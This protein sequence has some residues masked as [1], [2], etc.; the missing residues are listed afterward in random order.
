MHRR[1]YA[2][3]PR[4]D[5]PRVFASGIRTSVGPDFNPTDGTLWLTYNQ[6]DGMGDDIPPDEVN[7]ATTPGHNFGFPWYGGGHIRTNEY[8]DETPPE[9][10]R[11]P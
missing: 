5:R 8:K 3:G 10:P 4:W 6:V 11:V 7:R 2:N 1:H 9:R